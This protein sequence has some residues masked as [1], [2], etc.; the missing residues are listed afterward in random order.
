MKRKDIAARA[1]ADA[2]RLNSLLCQEP[3]AMRREARLV[4]QS[5][6]MQL[7]TLWSVAEN[8][9]EQLEERLL[10]LGVQLPE[11]SGSVLIRASAESLEEWLTPELAR[12]QGMLRR[13][14]GR[15]STH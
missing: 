4:L 5:L 6:T 9:V 8:E 13:T 12:I 15:S 1:R 11:D 14:V 10:G 2:L 7:L 3:A